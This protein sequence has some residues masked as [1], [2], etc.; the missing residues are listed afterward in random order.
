MGATTQVGSGECDCQRQSPAQLDQ[1]RGGLRLG[2]DALGPGNPSEQFQGLRRGEHV[3]VV[4]AGSVQPGEAAS[5]GDQHQAAR[6][7]RDQVSHLV[8]V[9]GVVQQDKH[10]PVVD[11]V[12]EHC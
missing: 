1:F 11:Q 10:L 9:D 8:L 7:G 3:E 12:P 4:R 5:A 2:C 6:A